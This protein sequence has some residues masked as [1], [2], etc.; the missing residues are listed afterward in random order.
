MQ[1]NRIKAI[2][3][4]DEYIICPECKG[5]RTVLSIK[6]GAGMEY[7]N[8]ICPTCMGVGYVLQRTVTSIFSIEGE[9][10]LK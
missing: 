7:I 8:K 1:N 2:Q 4:K 6:K 10:I 5:K 9:K 3:N